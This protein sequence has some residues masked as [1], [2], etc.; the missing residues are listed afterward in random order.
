MASGSSMLDNVTS[1]WSTSMDRIECLADKEQTGLSIR[2]EDTRGKPVD[3]LLPIVLTKHLFVA[4]EGR[5]NN[6]LWYVSWTEGK[7]GHTWLGDVRPK[8]SQSKQVACSAGWDFAHWLLLEFQGELIILYVF[9]IWIFPFW[10]LAMF[11]IC[12]SFYL[13]FLLWF[14]M[15][16][17]SHWIKFIGGFFFLIV[18]LKILF[19]ANGMNGKDTNRSG[20][21][22]F[23]NVFTLQDL[24][25]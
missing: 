3:D 5:S 7:Q 24:K 14:I 17:F 13:C 8:A 25:S 23:D 1:R 9:V 10:V 16:W 6:Y 20:P 11:N 21:F 18:Q 12:C 4:N 2:R 15:S 22:L 19:S